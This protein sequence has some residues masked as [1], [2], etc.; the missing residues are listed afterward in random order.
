MTQKSNL[1]FRGSPMQSKEDDDQKVEE[2]DDISR[3][4]LSI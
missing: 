4:S 2:E 3:Q 1:S